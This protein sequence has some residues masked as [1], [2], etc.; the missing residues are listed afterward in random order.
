M[1]TRYPTFFPERVNLWHGDRGF[2]AVGHEAGDYISLGTPA[3]LDA[4]GLLAA[5]TMSH[6]AAMTAGGFASAYD[7]TVMGLYGRNVTAVGLLT[8]GSAN[9]VTVEGYDYLNQPVIETLAP[10]GVS[11][12]NGKKAFK[13]VTKISWTPSSAG[14]TFNVGWGDVLGLPYKATALIDELEDDAAPTAGTFATAVTTDPATATTGDPRGTYDPNS[15]CDGSKEFKVRVKIDQDN[16]Y[17]VQH[18]N[19]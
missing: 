12:A 6:T 19:G 14:A 9:A 17:G 10:S 2:V 16:I 8:A 5:T 7:D 3:S 15:A 18:Y 11:A 4:D 1:T 13:R